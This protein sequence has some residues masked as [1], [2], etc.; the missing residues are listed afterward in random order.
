VARGGRTA[1]LNS[2]AHA[3]ITRQSLPVLQHISILL[4]G[5][6][7]QESTPSIHILLGDSLHRAPLSLSQTRAALYPIFSRNSGSLSLFLPLSVSIS[8]SHSSCVAVP[9]SLE[10]WKRNRGYRDRGKRGER[11]ICRDCAEM[12]ALQ[13]LYVASPS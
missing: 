13:V 8:S 4:A 7:Q 1:G 2:G 9:L 6:I 5:C 12:A 10:E 11:L 3:T